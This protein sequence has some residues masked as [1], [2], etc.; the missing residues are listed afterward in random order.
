MVA[1]IP[2]TLLDVDQLP[3]ADRAALGD[4]IACYGVFVIA[5]YSDGAMHCLVPSGLEDA[6]LFVIDRDIAPVDVMQAA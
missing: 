2:L 6:L 5:V 4:I 3:D 1:L